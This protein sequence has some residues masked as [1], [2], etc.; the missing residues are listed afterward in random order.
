M[1]WNLSLDPGL[2]LAADQD[3]DL[4]VLGLVLQAGGEVGGIPDDGV[5]DPLA[6]AEQADKDLAGVDPDAHLKSAGE[7]ASLLPGLVE[8]FSAWRISMAALAARTA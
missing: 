5:V 7:D 2:G 8:V 3:G 1:V 4:V 6:G